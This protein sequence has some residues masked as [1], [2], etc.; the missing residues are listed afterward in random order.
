[1]NNM[2]RFISIEKEKIDEGHSDTC[3]QYDKRFNDVQFYR[4]L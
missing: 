1:M 2:K 3:K 4:G